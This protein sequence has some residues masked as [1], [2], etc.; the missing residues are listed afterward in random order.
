MRGL[1]SGAVAA[2]PSAA[3]HHE[4]PARQHKHDKHPQTRRICS[5]P[6]SQSLFSINF[7]N[8]THVLGRIQTSSLQMLTKDTFAQ[9]LFPIQSRVQTSGTTVKMDLATLTMALTLLRLVLD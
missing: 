5:H 3:V 4:T 8:R 6:P 7:S 9:Q 1:A 2:F